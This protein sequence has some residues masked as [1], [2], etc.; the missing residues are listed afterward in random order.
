[1]TTIC[2]SAPVSA[3]VLEGSAPLVVDNEVVNLVECCTIRGPPCELMNAFVLEDC[4]A[5]YTVVV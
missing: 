1:M 4:T 3:D 5:N 2:I